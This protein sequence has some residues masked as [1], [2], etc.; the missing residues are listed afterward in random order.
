GHPALIG[1]H[2][3]ADAHAERGVGGGPTSEPKR[4]ISFVRAAQQGRCGRNTRPRLQTTPPPAP[5]LTSPNLFSVRSGSV[6][7]PP[8]LPSQLLGTTPRP[9]NLG[10]P[11]PRMSARSRSR[12]STLR[13][14][15]RSAWPTPMWTGRTP[16][17]RLE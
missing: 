12:T 6:A 11:P 4:T 7:G 5:P 9:P 15:P 14:R 17:G 8:P 16:A 3:E 2:A 1:A 10:A 13:V